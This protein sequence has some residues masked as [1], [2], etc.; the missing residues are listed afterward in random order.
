M[1]H[2]NVTTKINFSYLL[3]KRSWSRLQAEEILLI[4]IFQRTLYYF[5]TVFW[6]YI[7]VEWQTNKTITLACCIFIF[8]RP[9][10]AECNGT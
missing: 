9:A 6:S 5:L 10:G 3:M 7:I 1:C 8:F 2:R 4:K